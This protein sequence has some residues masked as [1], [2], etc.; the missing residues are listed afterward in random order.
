M[1]NAALWATDFRYLNDSQELIYAWNAFVAKLEQLS[2]TPGE[3][4]EAYAAQLKA[5]QLMKATDLMDFDDA[6]FVACFT[7]LG[8]A[9]SQ[10][11]RYGANGHGIAL[12]FDS[13][14]IRALKV[15]QYH[16]S[17]DGQLVPMTAIL[18]GADSSQNKEIEFTWG[19]FLQKVAYG[20]A[21]SATESWTA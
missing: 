17:R 9:L 11:S 21:R 15:P 2:S 14:R 18:A 10:W 12:G 19:A 5:L 1:Q 3:Y 20:D 7:E 16:H 4:S 13:E 8:D 6:M